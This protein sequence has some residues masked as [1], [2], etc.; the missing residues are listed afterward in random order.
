MVPS[1]TTAQDIT[2]THCIYQTS[3][4]SHFFLSL[5]MQRRHVNHT[6]EARAIC[7]NFFSLSEFFGCATIVGIE[8]ILMHKV[9]YIIAL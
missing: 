2:T 1:E 3:C 5:Y 6:V 7:Y 9:T 4:H 8:M